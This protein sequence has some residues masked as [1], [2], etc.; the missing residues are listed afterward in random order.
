MQR[1]VPAALCAGWPQIRSSTSRSSASEGYFA[2]VLQHFSASVHLDVEAQ[3]GGDAGSLTPG[4]SA[5]LAPLL[6]TG[7]DK[8]C[9]QVICLQHNHHNHHTRSHFGS[10]HFGSRAISVR[11]GIATVSLRV[12]NFRLCLVAMVLGMVGRRRLVVSFVCSFAR[13]LVFLVVTSGAVSGCLPTFG[14]H[15]YAATA[16]KI[17]Q[18]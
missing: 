18:P 10:S 11:T 7:M 4:R 1:Q 2:A 13:V 14:Q 15:P 12:Q 8:H 9:R 5:T 6:P 16:G 3:G 17:R